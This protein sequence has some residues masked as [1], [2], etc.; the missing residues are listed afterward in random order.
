MQFNPPFGIEIEIRESNSVYQ[1]Y[2]D[3]LV[4]HFHEHVLGF[5]PDMCAILNIVKGKETQLKIFVC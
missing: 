5:R 4:Y 2:R 3:V 1:L